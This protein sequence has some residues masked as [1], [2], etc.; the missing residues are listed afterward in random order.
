MSHHHIIPRSRRSGRNNKNNIVSVDK[1]QH[2][3]YHALFA[4]MTPDEILKYLVE[5]FWGGQWHFV[6]QA[7]AHASK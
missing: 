2:E 6:N 7:L 5:E 3:H 4:N 1:K